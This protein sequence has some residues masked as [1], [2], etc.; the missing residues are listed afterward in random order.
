M[1]TFRCVSDLDGVEQTASAQTLNECGYLER[2]KHFRHLSP[3]VV[4]CHL[5]KSN[6]KLTALL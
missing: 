2:Y 1:C 6:L 3:S 4:T 5:G